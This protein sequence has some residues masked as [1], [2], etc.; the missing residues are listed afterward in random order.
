MAEL[1]AESKR[2]DARSAGRAAK[3][4]FLERAREQ[5]RV[6][7][8]Q[9]AAFAA[10]SGQVDAAEARVREAEAA[11]DAARVQCAI[12]QAAAVD[13]LKAIGLSVADIAESC[14]TTPTEIRRIVRIAAE[15][16]DGEQADDGPA[17]A[18]G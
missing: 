4:T 13:E 11:A 6:V 15:H 9:C 3:A 1:A 17:V 7:E 10:A 12:T 8:Q 16:N 5:A 14:D 2:M 18:A